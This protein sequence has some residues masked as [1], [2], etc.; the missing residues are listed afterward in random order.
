MEH[1][2]NSNEVYLFWSQIKFSGAYMHSTKGAISGCPTKMCDLEV[3]DSI[4]S[5]E[6]DLFVG[7]VSMQPLSTPLTHHIAVTFARNI[8]WKQDVFWDTI[9]LKLLK[10]WNTFMDS[11]E[12]YFVI[13]PSGAPL[14]HWLWTWQGQQGLLGEN[15][16]DI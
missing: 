2:T 10:K 8:K 12:G 5:K 13:Q 16:K 11:I 6:V 9:I 4:N 3:G 14:A 1:S 15:K 7:L